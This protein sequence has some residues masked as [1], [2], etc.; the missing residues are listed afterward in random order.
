MT[1]LQPREAYRRLAEDYDASPNALIALEQRTMAP[2]LPVSLERHTVVDVAA[3]TGRWAQHC[4][5][6]GARIIA[7]DLCHEMLCRASRHA[8]QG[9]LVQADAEWL[10]LPDA[11]ADIVICA[12]AVGYAPACFAEL[13]RITRKGG[14]LLVSDVHPEALDRGWTRSFRHRGAVIRV[15]DQPYGLADLYAPGLQLSCLIEPRLGAP[16][17]EFFERA[18][19]LDRFDEACRE[20]AIFVARWIR[21]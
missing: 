4:A 14:M 15:S 21:M 10:P 6:R 5:K 2:L 20:P 12:F 13:A 18:G 16:E 11:S 17:R 3:G 7:V 8:V 9:G 19:R 1:V